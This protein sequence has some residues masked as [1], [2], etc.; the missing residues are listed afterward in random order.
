MNISQ[1]NLASQGELHIAAFTDKD[2]NI[3]DG[4]GPGGVPTMLLIEG[5]TRYY[6]VDAVFA[7]QKKNSLP[8]GGKIMFWTWSAKDRRYLDS[9]KA[10][11]EELARRHPDVPV[12]SSVPGVA[13]C[14]DLAKVAGE[15]AKLA[16]DNKGKVPHDQ[17][18]NALGHMF[19]ACH[20]L[21]LSEAQIVKAFRTEYPA[22]QPQQPAAKA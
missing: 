8:A 14:R 10:D 2:G 7:M 15:I 12:P 16:K 9:T 18:L 22:Q 4:K 20:E 21:G 17:V 6:I 3:L 19:K 5:N 13:A 1:L 11:I